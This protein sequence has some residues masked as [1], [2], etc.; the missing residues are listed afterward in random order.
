MNNPSNPGSNANGANRSQLQNQRNDPAR[1]TQAQ[2]RINQGQGNP[3]QQNQA[4]TQW[5]GGQP[6]EANRDA[7]RR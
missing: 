6:D 1:P 5:N 3:S 2:S 7:N 4:E